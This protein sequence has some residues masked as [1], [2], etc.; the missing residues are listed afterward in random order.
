MSSGYVVIVIGGGSS[1]GHRAGA[2]AEG[3]LRVALAEHELVGGECS[4]KLLAPELNS[5]R[6]GLDRIVLLGVE[7]EQLE[8]PQHMRGQGRGNV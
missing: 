7:A 5:L 4:C 2:L 3:G 8:R 6:R 1:G